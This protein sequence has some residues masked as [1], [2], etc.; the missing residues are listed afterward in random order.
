MDGKEEWWKDKHRARLLLPMLCQLCHQ[1]IKTA[2]TL[3]TLLSFLSLSI[4]IY[5]TFLYV[6]QFIYHPWHLSSCLFLS[7]KKVSIYRFTCCNTR[8]RMKNR[9]E[10]RNETGQKP[11]MRGE[12]IRLEAEK[13]STMYES[14]FTSWQWHLVNCYISP[15][16]T[17]SIRDHTLHTCYTHIHY[18][19]VPFPAR[20]IIVPLHSEK[21]R[22]ACRYSQT[23]SRVDRVAGR[24]MAVNTCTKRMKSLS[25]KL[26]MRPIQNIKC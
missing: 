17:P 21:Q 12:K 2:D 13:G 20:W 25:L 6:H 16:K 4:H 24:Q 15:R 3:L 23:G 5:S 11:W 26:Q 18:G 9:K 8:R 1:L 7:E 22:E 19:S 10:N 14:I